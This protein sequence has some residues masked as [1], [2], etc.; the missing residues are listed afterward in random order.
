MP[1]SQVNDGEGMGGLTLGFENIGKAL[2]T[3]QKV[4]VSGGLGVRR[5]IAL[6]IHHSH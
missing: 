3:A 6:P 1:I 2:N 4:R 5:L